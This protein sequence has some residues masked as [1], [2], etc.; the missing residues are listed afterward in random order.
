MKVQI[1]GEDREVGD[2]SCLEDLLESLGIPLSTLLVEHNGLALR[3][4]EWAGRSISEG[5]RFEMIRIVAGG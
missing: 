4:E 3:R 2:V 5:D 1:N